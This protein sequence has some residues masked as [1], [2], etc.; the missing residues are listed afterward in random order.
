MKLDFL[1][2]FKKLFFW[3]IGI[4]A[5]LFVFR[6]VYGYVV[7]R[8]AD[9]TSGPVYFESISNTRNN[10]ATKKYKA[11]VSNSSA[12]IQV[13]QK[14]EKI[15]EIKTKSSKF[16]E[17]EKS[18]RVII[19]KLDALIQF[20][21]KSGNPGYRKLSF[22]IGVPPDNF[23][24][25]YDQLIKIGKVQA[26][27]ITKKDKTNE[28]KEL[29]AKKQSLEKIR[30]SLIEL[31]SKGGK[32]EEYMGLENRILEIE[33]NLQGLG[34]SLGDFDDENEFCTV[35]F[36]LAEIKALEAEHISF[37][38]RVK[39]ALEWSIRIYTRLLIMLFFISGASF[40]ILFTIDKG[41]ALLKVDNSLKKDQ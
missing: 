19:E 40:L 14:Y 35:K 4:F 28:Y 17:E 13:D 36:S 26:K 6:L 34:V 1:R 3:F 41:K 10:Y 20:E 9:D 7:V 31:K 5:V 33:Q 16:K 27:Q 23:D 11:N 30:A 29:N 37:V 38:H 12:S 2:R 22:I 24:K 39:V 18:A 32:I 25:I 21:Q 15:A 8:E